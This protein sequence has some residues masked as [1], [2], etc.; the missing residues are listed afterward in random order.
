MHH[1]INP[2]GITI[3]I[4]LFKGQED[5]IIPGIKGAQLHSLLMAS[6]FKSHEKCIVITEMS[7]T[8]KPS[9]H[10]VTQGDLVLYFQHVQASWFWFFSLIRQTIPTSTEMLFHK[11]SRLLQCFR[12]AVGADAWEIRYSVTDVGI[13]KIKMRE[14]EEW[15]KKGEWKE[16]QKEKGERW[17]EWDFKSRRPGLKSQLYNVV[18][19]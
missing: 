1:D 19:A 15:E 10:C 14:R 9:W 7:V 17:G 18:V 12:G 11:E 13:S 8:T 6:C 5:L 2:S 3:Q 4:F 16:K